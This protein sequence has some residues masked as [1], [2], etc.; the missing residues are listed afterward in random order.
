MG[1]RMPRSY[2]T[3]S[4]VCQTHSGSQILGGFI[5]KPGAAGH[6]LGSAI[7]AFTDGRVKW[8]ILKDFYFAWFELNQNIRTRETQWRCSLLLHL[9][10]L[11]QLTSSSRET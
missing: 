5:G 10:Q 4:R 9:G 1:K 3:G 2:K 11:R 8:P 6:R 7:E